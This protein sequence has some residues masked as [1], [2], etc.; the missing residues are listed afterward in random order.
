MTV[1]CLVDAV[2]DV[3]SLAEDSEHP[4]PSA[5]GQVDNHILD[6]GRELQVGHYGSHPL[7]LRGIAEPQP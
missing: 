1:G 5:C 6:G 3:I 2:S 4:T 7:E